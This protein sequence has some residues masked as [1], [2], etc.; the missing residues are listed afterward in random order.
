MSEIL[1]LA[2]DCAVSSRSKPRES[3]NWAAYCK[4]G[5]LTSKLQFGKKLATFFVT[6][7][8]SKLLVE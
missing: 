3:A 6:R 8:R 1:I 7:F 5:G 2:I 4:N